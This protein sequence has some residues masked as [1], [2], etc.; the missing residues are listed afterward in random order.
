M[1]SAPEY[2]ALMGLLVLLSIAGAIIL[3]V[4]NADI[5]TW[6]LEN[7]EEPDAPSF[8]KLIGKAER[9]EVLERAPATNVSAPAGSGTSKCGSRC[10]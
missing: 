6:M 8:D 2:G 1:N 10:F 9:L 7:G 3:S 4:K 5:E